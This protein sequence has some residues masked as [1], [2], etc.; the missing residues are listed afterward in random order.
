MK[1]GDLA[2]IRDSWKPFGSNAKNYPASG[3]L[4]LIVGL[5][6]NE[7]SSIFKVLSS[8]GVVNFHMSYLEV[9]DETG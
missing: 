2:R 3:E 5:Q 9:L 4:V 8:K 7:I 1:P 6:Y